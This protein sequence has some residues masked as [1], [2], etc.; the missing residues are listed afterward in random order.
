MAAFNEKT[1]PGHSVSWV[2]GWGGVGGT[3]YVFGL[4]VCDTSNR[5]AMSLSLIFSLRRGCT[6][7]ANPRDNG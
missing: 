4:I 5:W 6:S 7:A 3:G 1:Q 2:G